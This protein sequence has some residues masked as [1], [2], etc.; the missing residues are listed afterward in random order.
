MAKTRP[1]KAQRRLGG[2]SKG[3]SWLNR[4]KGQ[5]CAK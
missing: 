3:S 1:T 5:F 2:K 4:K